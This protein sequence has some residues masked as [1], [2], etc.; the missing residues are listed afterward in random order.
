MPATDPSVPA[1]FDAGWVPTNTFPG[2]SGCGSNPWA[3][4]SVVGSPSSWTDQEHL[5]GALLERG[6]R[7]VLRSDEDLWSNVVGDVVIAQSIFRFHACSS[8]FAFAGPSS[9]S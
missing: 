1:V 2:G 9:T 3:A 5:P 6:E 8:R 4:A 7:A